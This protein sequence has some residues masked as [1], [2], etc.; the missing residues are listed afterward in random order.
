M[1]KENNFNG[2]K[3]DVKSVTS[4]TSMLSRGYYRAPRS[5]YGKTRLL[6]NNHNHKNDNKNIGRAMISEYDY[7]SKY[8]FLIGF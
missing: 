3:D 4:H 5:N 6:D 8:P 7:K 1:K 2:L